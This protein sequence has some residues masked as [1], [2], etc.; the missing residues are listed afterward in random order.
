MNRGTPVAQLGQTQLNVSPPRRK[1]MHC[2]C[3][4][5]TVLP[6]TTGCTGSPDSGSDFPTGSPP[7]SVLSANVFQICSVLEF[8]N[9]TWD[10]IQN[11]MERTC[12]DFVSVR[13]IKGRSID[14]G[15]SPG[16]GGGRGGRLRTAALVGGRAVVRVLG[17]ASLRTDAGGRLRASSRHWMDRGDLEDGV[18]GAPGGGR[19]GCA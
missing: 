3:V 11:G 12:I 5:F 17:S 19:G 16:G 9:S 2:V 4:L 6:I 7:P 8:V 1:P 15:R 18:L 10:R 14:G 13:T